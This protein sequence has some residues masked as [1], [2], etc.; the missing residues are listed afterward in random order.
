MESAA[1]QFTV[2]VQENK[3]IG[4]A[5]IKFIITDADAPPNAAPYT[6][7]FR[8]GN[9]M[10]AF[11]IEQDGILRTATR[12]NHKIKDNYRVQIRVFDNGTP[13]LYSDAWV[14]VKGN[15]TLPQQCKNSNM[16]FFL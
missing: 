5:L 16:T 14:L 9:E 2:F 12:F 13:P 15:R 7:D 1:S 8:S 3:P 10:G 11:R 4:H 6:F